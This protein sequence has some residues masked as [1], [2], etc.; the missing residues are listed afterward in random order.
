MLIVFQELLLSLFGIV[1]STGPEFFLDQRTALVFC[2]PSQ[3]FEGYC[4]GFLIR[5]TIL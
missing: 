4:I 2:Q 1:K 3:V 5:N